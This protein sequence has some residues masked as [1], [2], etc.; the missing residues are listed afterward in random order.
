MGALIPV[1][2]GRQTLITLMHDQSL[3]LGKHFELAVGDDDRDLDDTVVGRIKTGH[4][5]VQPGQVVLI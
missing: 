4:L 2:H 5:H 3:G 1:I